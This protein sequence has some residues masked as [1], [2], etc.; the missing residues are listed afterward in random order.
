MQEDLKRIKDS[1]VS[2]SLSLAKALETNST[3]DIKEVAKECRSIECAC[4]QLI[5]SLSE[6]KELIDEQEAFK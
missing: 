6:L 3:E 1:L 5:F 2:W 4:D